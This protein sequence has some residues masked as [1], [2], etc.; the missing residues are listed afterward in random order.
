VCNEPM[1]RTGSLSGQMVCEVHCSKCGH[2]R[3]FEDYLD[4]CSI[5]DRDGGPCAHRPPGTE[6]S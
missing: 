2:D 6:K 5:C 1:T 4:F 3:V